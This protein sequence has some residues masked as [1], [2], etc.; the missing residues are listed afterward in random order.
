MQLMLSM[1]AAAELLGVAALL[2]QAYLPQ[3]SNN[4]SELQAGHAHGSS[5][6][7]KPKG[8]ARP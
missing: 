8:A 2:S 4:P 7:T 5:L 1:L 3:A 6:S